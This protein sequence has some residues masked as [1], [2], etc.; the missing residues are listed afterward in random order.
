MTPDITRRLN[1]IDRSLSALEQRWPSQRDDIGL[2]PRDYQEI[3]DCQ[4]VAEQSH[5][6][7]AL[8]AIWAKP[9]L[10]HV[11]YDGVA[12]YRDARDDGCSWSVALK[13]TIALLLDRRWSRRA[14]DAWKARTGWT[15]TDSHDVCF[16]DAR[17]DGYGHS[18]MVCWLY[19]GLRISI[20]SDGD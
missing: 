17:S 8:K 18:A 11:R 15:C 3:A 16:W 10:R 2:S 19:P 4:K 9:V 5:R 7:R 13:A 6:W 20:F 1:K 12:I 14:D